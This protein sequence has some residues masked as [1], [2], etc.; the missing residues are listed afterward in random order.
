[1]PARDFSRRRF[2]TAATCLLA[3]T[4]HA[5]GRAGQG[6]SWP[7]QPVKWVI[8]FAPGGGADTIARLL[9]PSLAAD[10]K[11][12]VIVE[13][14]PGA[15][16]IVGSD[17]V[18]KAPADGHTWLMSNNASSAIAPLLYPKPPYHPLNDFVHVAMIG[19]FANALLVRADHPA[20]SFADFVRLCKQFPGKYTYASAGPGSAG[21]LT[22]ELLKIEAG[23]DITHVP[24]K[25][26]G[27]A[28]I[29]LISGQID[30]LF[31][32][33]PASIGYVNGGKLRA[34]AISS[35][36]RIANL[37]NAPAIAETYPRVI[38]TA[39]FG[40]SMPKGVP[41]EIAQRVASSTA[42]VLKMPELRKRLEDIGV[43]ASGI[44]AAAYTQFIESER[45]RWKAVIDAAKIRIE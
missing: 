44:G 13:N 23:I 16:G 10:L 9:L 39:W 22:G 8:P 43:V 33:L 15:S 25:G 11:A 26:T 41:N 27:P 31:D 6:G 18:A 5:Q 29:D 36:E 14:R 19:G 38:G 28:I 20:K 32:G 21:H 3:Q 30:A 35:R 24:Y 17:A 1:M 2:L 37:P 42:R 34:L 40:I 12:N 7:S 45:E 4:V